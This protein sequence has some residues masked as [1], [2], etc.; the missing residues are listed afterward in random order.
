MDNSEL[1][2][3]KFDFV[4]KGHNVFSELSTLL[5]STQVVG[6]HFNHNDT[7]LRNGNKNPIL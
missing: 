5:G 2:C 6:L 7:V 4:G 1:N 3:K